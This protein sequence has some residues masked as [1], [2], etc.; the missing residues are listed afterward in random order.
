MTMQDS[1]VITYGVIGCGMMGQEHLRN[2]AV[3][4]QM[5]PLRNAVHRSALLRLVHTYTQLRAQHTST[6]LPTAHEVA[7]VMDVN[8]AVDATPISLIEAV[9]S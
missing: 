1:R 5:V 3:E 4:L 7:M 9:I 8:E 2:I 6:D